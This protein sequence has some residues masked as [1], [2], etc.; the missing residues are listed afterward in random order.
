VLTANS[1]S[2][3]TSGD[4]LIAALPGITEPPVI[5]SRTTQ[6]RIPELTITKILKKYVQIRNPL[7][8]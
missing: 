3:K 1:S 6:P 4:Y 7:C 2:E 8:R 5:E